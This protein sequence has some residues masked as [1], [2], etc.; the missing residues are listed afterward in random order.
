ML[1]ELRVYMP[2]QDYTGIPD[3]FEASSLTNAKR[4]VRQIINSHPEL[5][6]M[7]FSKKWSGVYG[8]RFT[9]RESERLDVCACSRYLKQG[10]PTAIFLKWRQNHEDIK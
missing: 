2:L 3:N 7:E 9:G 8:M 10:G 6:K 1:F 4:M 5:C